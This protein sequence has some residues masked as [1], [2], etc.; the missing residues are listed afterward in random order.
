VYYHGYLDRQKRGIWRVP[1]SGGPETLVLDRAL[2]PTRWDLADRGIY[3]VDTNVRPFAICFYDFATRLT[4]HLTS[5][6]R[7]PGFDISAG[8]SIS[9]NGNWLLYCGGFRT[10]DI[11][12][13]DNFR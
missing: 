7:E 9:P 10:S 11:M 1:V 12:M 3:F 5:V 4:S 8:F 6:N 2:S 13:I